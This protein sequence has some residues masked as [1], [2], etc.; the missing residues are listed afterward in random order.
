VDRVEEGQEEQ[1]AAKRQFLAT[2]ERFRELAGTGP[3][4][5]EDAYA[6]LAD[7]LEDCESRARAVSERIGSIEQVSQDLFDEWQAEIGQMSS[8]DLKRQSQASLEQS[9]E[10][11]G[12]LIGAMKQAESKMEPVLVAFRDHV[13]FLK[14]NLNARAVASLQATV[15]E[16][17]GQVSQLVQDMQASIE[18]AD[19]FISSLESP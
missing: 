8:A 12:E 6:E 4:E 13:L 5:L 1:D 14:H 2:F 7:E 19:A 18:K 11:Y 17:E 9:R 16:I 15:V 3:D 10:R